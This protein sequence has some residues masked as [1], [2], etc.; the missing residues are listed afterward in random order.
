[1]VYDNIHN[2]ETTDDH[3]SNPHH[4]VGCFISGYRDAKILTRTKLG[5]GVL[6]I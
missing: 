6:K 5:L 1:M 3:N 4:T 2:A